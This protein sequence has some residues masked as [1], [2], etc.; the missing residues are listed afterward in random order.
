MIILFIRSPNKDTPNLKAPL[1]T[2]DPRPESPNPV[3]TLCSPALVRKGPMEYVLPQTQVRGSDPSVG[4]IS[5]GLQVQ[6]LG[7][8]VQFLGLGFQV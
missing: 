6:G 4:K 5:L 1:C 3:Q 8:R 7:F 2:L